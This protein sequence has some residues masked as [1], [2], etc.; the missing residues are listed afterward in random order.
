M[1]QL[2]N[3]K[4]LESVIVC[5]YDRSH[6]KKCD[7]YYECVTCSKRYPLLDGIINF[8]AHDESFPNLS[9]EIPWHQV[10]EL[11][12]PNKLL[13]KIRKLPIYP[14]LLLTSDH[15][16]FTLE[17]WVYHAMQRSKA[18]LDI[19]CREGTNLQYGSYAD[20]CVGIDVDL[21]AVRY[22]YVMSAHNAHTLLASGTRLPFTDKSFDLIVCIDVIEHILE[23]AEVFKEMARV[24]KHNAQLIISTPS[25][26]VV[27][28]PY[29]LHHKHFT[30]DEL[31]T[32]I[33]HDFLITK[34]ITVVRNCMVRKFYWS[35]LNKFSTNRL[36]TLPLN[37]L[38]NCLYYLFGYHLQKSYMRSDV[39]DATFIIKATRR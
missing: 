18:V 31:L 15:F 19:G 20:I 2:K 8:L 14:R 4:A 33:G 5:P 23:Y 21:E 17:R 37:I 13:S 25:G 9:Y 29:P 16:S 22:A 11:N 7:G 27:P 32:L 38:S 39:T 34:A 35:F 12:T 10:P 1:S 24:S 30:Q 3:I 6:L 36:L 28:K 26:D